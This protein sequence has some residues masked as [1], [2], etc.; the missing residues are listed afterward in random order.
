[1]V[2]LSHD[3]VINRA[4]WNAYAANGR[5]SRIFKGFIRAIREFVAFALRISRF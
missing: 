3:R 5:I 1:M 4:V 2:S